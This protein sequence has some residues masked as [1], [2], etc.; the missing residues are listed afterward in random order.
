MPAVFGRMSHLARFTNV[1]KNTIKPIAQVGVN[2]PALGRLGFFIQKSTFRTIPRNIVVSSKRTFSS[3]PSDEAILAEE[4]DVQATLVQRSEEWAA[5][6]TS[7]DS[8]YF[9][10]GAKVHTPK[11]LYI[12]C[13]DARVPASQILGMEAG[14]LFVHRNVANLVVNT[15]TSILSGVQCATEEDHGLNVIEHWLNNIRD[16]VRMHKDELDAIEDKDARLRRLVELNTVEQAGN[17]LKNPVVQQSRAETGYPRVHGF[18]YD[19]RDGLL[20]A[21]DFKESITAHVKANEDTF[22]LF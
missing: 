13:S 2:Q 14:E 20:K 5:R 15:D 12:G 1:L 11:Y 7:Q 17:V 21:M 4:D 6:K 16:V 10:E 9:S 8:G 19:I 18:V 22:K 3:K